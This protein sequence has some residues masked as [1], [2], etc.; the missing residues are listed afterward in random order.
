MKKIL[1]K[2]VDYI[3]NTIQ[4]ARIKLILEKYKIDNKSFEDGRKLGYSKGFIEG[5]E[6]R[7]QRHESVKKEDYE[8]LI[9]Y[10]VTH[11][12]E[13]VYCL[14]SPEGTGLMVRYKEKTI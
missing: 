7:A 1:K 4:N 6:L 14:N 13:L 10:L 12:L 11:N 2:I 9:R 5:T 8:G 3:F